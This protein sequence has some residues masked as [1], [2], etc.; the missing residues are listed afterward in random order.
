MCVLVIGDA[1]DAP[2]LSAAQ[3]SMRLHGQAFAVVIATGENCAGDFGITR[4][5]S[6]ALRHAG[7]DVLTPGGGAV[8]LPAR[9]GSRITVGQV[10]G[11]LLMDPLNDPF[12]AAGLD[13][14]VVV[15]MHAEATSEKMVL[16]RQASQTSSRR[17][18]RPAT[19]FILG[20]TA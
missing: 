9:D 11:R 10:I 18:H 3:A 1:Y 14:A 17:H 2:R 15:E 20:E 6:R 16:G 7:V 5:G 4:A 8:T 12:E 19:T 13:A